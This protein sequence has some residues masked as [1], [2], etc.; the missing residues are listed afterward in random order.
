MHNSLI[1]G[2]I[3][4]AE[5]MFYIFFLFFLG[6]VI[7]LRRE[8]RR[9]GYPVEDDIGGRL[10][11]DETLFNTALPKTFNLPFGQG[12]YTAPNNARDPIEVA[13]ARRVSPWPGAPIEPVGDPI[14]AGVGPGARA[15]R[16]KFADVT[17]EGHL[18]IVPIGDATGTT[19][20]TRDVDPRGLTVRGADGEIAGK[21]SDIWVDRSEMLIRY[22]EV[23]TGSRKVLMPMTMAFVSR[24]RNNVTCS[25]LAAGQFGG[26]PHPAK[27]GEITRDE[28][29]QIVAYF[30]GGYLYATPSRQ[31]PKL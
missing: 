4:I 1:A 12:S 26:A 19:V 9:E 3:D 20:E 15:H 17:A 30:G 27:A 24:S 10:R 22:L 8:D 14:M 21:V 28:E 25:A 7:Y 16:A 23:D 18:R 31:E 11:R 29:E 13:N 5:L 2:S 6:L